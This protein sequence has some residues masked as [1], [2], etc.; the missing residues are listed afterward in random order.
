MKSAMKHVFLVLLFLLCVSCSSDRDTSAILDQVEALIDENPVAAY[1]LVKGI[2]GAAIRSSAVNARYAL[3]YTRAEYK[4]YID[5][6]TDSLIS[7]AA[8]YYERHGSEKEKFYAYLYQGCVNYGI[9]DYNSNMKAVDVLLKACS[10]VDAVD[11]YKDVGLMYIQL[12][13]LYGEQQATDEEA[14]ARKAYNAYEKAGMEAHATNAMAHIAASL[15][16]QG[17]YERCLYYSDTILNKAISIKD[18]VDIVNALVKKTQCAIRLQRFSLGDSIYRTLKSDYNYRYDSQ[19]YSQLAVIQASKNNQ[20][21]AE[22]YIGCARK[23]ADNFNDSLQCYIFSSRVYSKLHLDSLA[24]AYKDSAFLLENRLLVAS[25]H[26]TALAVQRD[27]LEMQFE[28]AELTHRQN[29]LYL[30]VVILILSLVIIIVV[31][32]ARRQ[33]LMTRLQSEKIK[34]LLSELNKDRH[35]LNEGLYKLRHSEIIC[36][37]KEALAKGLSI[38]DEDWKEMEASFCKYLPSFEQTLLAVHEMSQIEWRVCM[39]LKAGFSSSDI[40]RIVNKSPTAIPSIRSRLYSKFFMK[41][42]K[43]SDW[44]VFIDSI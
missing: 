35:L 24:Y 15:L 39:L 30:A 9:K 25:L 1:D 4:N 22:H 5:A 31:D 10:Y 18:T 37:F 36:S 32:Y 40:A 28:N 33:K 13:T 26:H 14:C 16:H 42:G 7:I 34:N 20:I 19:D 44:D 21:D 29:L 23:T 12:S 41:K 43:A 6:P 11:N 17:D 8:D 3:L 2:D 27:Y 38:H